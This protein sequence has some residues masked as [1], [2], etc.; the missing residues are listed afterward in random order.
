MFQQIGFFTCNYPLA[1][2]AGTGSASAE[3]GRAGYSGLRRRKERF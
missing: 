2:D 1:L 3:G